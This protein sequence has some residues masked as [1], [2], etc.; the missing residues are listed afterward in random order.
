MLPTHTRPLARLVLLSLMLTFIA[1]RLV[2]IL[3]VLHRMP[4]IYLHVRDTHVHHLNTGSS[5]SRRRGVSAVQLRPSGP[6]E[7]VRRSD[8]HDVH[9]ARA[10]P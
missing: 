9:R 5:S 2:S 1:A 10:L 6:G 7:P 8:Q 4:N 3:I